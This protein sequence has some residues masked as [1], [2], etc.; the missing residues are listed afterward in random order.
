V[1]HAIRARG[2]ADL[3]EGRQRDHFALV[4]A[5]FQL[6]DL[7][8][9]KAEL[10]FGLNVDLI[11]AS[12]A[13]E[14]VGIQRTQVNLQGV[15]DVADGHAVGLGFFPVDSGIDLRHVHGV[16]GEQPGQFRNTLWLL[17]MMFMVSLYS[18]S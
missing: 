14:V 2:V 18:S 10:L 9:F 5:H 17:V 1:H 12:E 4:V 7:I 15:E 16:T 6:T 11:G 13:V 8:G 3:D